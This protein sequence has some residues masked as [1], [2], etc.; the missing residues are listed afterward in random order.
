M[1][2]FLFIMFI[3]LAGCA[4]PADEWETTRSKNIEQA[5]QKIL[6][7]NKKEMERTK[8]VQ[9]LSN[10]P[11][12]KA[13][14]KQATEDKIYAPA[15]DNAV[16][17]LLKARG[18]FPAPKEQIESALRDLQPYV[19]LG[20]EAAIQNGQAEEADRLLSTMKIMDES[21]T[22]IPRLT[23]EITAM[24]NKSLQNR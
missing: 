5:N 14:L 15:G 16:E 23:E 12:Y 21:A 18:S 6:E 10:N 17:S 19:I 2:N 20:I 4:G 11:Y 8:E 24:K 1:R 13:H 3:G 9:A 22:S 7:A